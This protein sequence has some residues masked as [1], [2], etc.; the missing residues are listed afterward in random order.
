M[1]SSRAQEPSP[2]L[3]FQM[4]MYLGCRFGIV[5]APPQGR[6]AVTGIVAPQPGATGTDSL[7]LPSKD[8]QT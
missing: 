5:G 3:I 1:D 4:E 7:K 6:R 8:P 2:G